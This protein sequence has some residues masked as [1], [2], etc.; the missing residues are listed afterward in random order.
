M[1]MVLLFSNIILWVIVLFNFILT[2]ALIR[3]GT[4]AEARKAPQGLLAGEEAPAFSAK[5]LAGEEVG[6]STFAGR[7]VAFIFFG[8]NCEPCMEALPDYEALYPKAKRR[9]TEIILVATDTNELARTFVEE[10]QVQ[11]PMVV[12][13]KSFMTDYKLRGTPSYTVCKFRL[14]SLRDSGVKSGIAV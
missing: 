12:A 4:T 2:L 8:L 5:T 10:H 3:R 13:D 11:L 9:G 14:S 1:D 6:L 7:N